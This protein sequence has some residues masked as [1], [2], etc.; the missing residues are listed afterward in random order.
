MGFKDFVGSWASILGLEDEI[1]GGLS[2]ISGSLTSIFVIHRPH[3]LVTTLSFNIKL[4]WNRSRILAK[5]LNP[6]E[7]VPACREPWMWVVTVPDGSNA[8][9]VT[10]D[11]HG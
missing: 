11:S 6:G 8:F 7:I 5:V 1:A 2:I 10:T 4:L 3:E 9:P